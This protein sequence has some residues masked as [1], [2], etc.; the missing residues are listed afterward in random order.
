MPLAKIQVVE[1]RYDET[2]MAKVSGAVQAALM[3]R[4]CIPPKDP[5]QLI[6]E[7]PQ[8]RFLFCPLGGRGE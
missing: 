4:L 7:F 6:F 5:Y 3:N 8:K 2:W 1:G